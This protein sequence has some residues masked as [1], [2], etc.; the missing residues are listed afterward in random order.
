MP[1]LGA[2][3]GFHKHMDCNTRGDGLKDENSGGVYGALG[4]FGLRDLDFE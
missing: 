2:G 3:I 1:G 4:L